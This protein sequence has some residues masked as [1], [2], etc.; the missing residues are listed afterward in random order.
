MTLPRRPP[1]EQPDP[2]G[3]R[4]LLAEDNER[5]ADLVATALAAAGYEVVVAH[6]GYNALA[7][8]REQ[9]FDLLLTDWMMPGLTGGALATWVRDAR[10]L[11]P[12][13]LMTASEQAVIDSPL[14]AAVIRKPFGLDDLVAVVGAAV[15]VHELARES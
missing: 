3:R 5:L 12:M 10:P 7:L 4:V 6:D 1:D 9:P 11:L 2:A 15:E 13:I 8:A 14:W